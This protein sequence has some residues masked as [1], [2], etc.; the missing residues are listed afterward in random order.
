MAGIAGLLAVETVIGGRV[1]VGGDVRTRL[2]RRVYNAPPLIAF[3]HFGIEKVGTILGLFM[4]FFGVGTSSG[5]LG[6]W[7]DFR[8]D[9]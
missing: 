6:G 1:L 2:R 3:E 9:S 7:D 8:S 4:M 5:G